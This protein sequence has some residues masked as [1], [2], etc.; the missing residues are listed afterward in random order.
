MRN[1]IILILAGILLI[2][3]RAADAGCT[4]PEDEN[5]TRCNSCGNLEQNVKRA[6]DLAWNEFLKNQLMQLELRVNGATLVHLINPPHSSPGVLYYT[7]LIEDPDFEIINVETHAEA[8]QLLR[9]WGI[10]VTASPSRM[11]AEWMFRQQL[12]TRIEEILSTS[13]STGSSPYIMR[14]LDSKGNLVEGGTVQ[15][16]RLTGE[17]Q[18]ALAGPSDL[19][20]DDQYANEHCVPEDPRQE[21]DETAGADTSSGG[22]WSDNGESWEGWG[23]GYGDIRPLCRPDF[24]DPAGAGVICV[25]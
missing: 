12:S 16:P 25:I 5:Q 6:H 22:D 14:L 15:Q 7:V 23:N 3:S 21:S 19:L 13:V 9:S 18:V 17:Q 1:P 11:Q 20:P 2:L 8:V 4:A 24:S 10:G